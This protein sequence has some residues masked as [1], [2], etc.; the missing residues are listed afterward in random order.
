MI[1]PYFFINKDLKN[2]F[3][4]KLESHNIN[5]AVSILTFYQF[6]QMSVLKQDILKNF[7][8]NSYFLR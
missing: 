7:K 1:N 5:H 3:K 4:I 8:R 2:I 6:I